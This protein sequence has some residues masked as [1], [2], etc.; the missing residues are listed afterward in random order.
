MKEKSTI[1]LRTY[2]ETIQII[3]TSLTRHTAQ[4]LI[5]G[6]KDSHELAKI[7]SY[8]KEKEHSFLQY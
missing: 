8:I 1:T 3:T 4:V 2:N 5:T 7:I 6:A